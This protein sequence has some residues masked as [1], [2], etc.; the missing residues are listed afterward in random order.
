MMMPRLTPEQMLGILRER[1]VPE[2][3][4]RRW[5]EHDAT[6]AADATGAVLEKR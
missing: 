6:H 4:A 5:L 3:E 1:G 2:S